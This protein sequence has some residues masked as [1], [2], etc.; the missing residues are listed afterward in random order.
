MAEIECP[1]CK[2]FFTQS[3]KK[4][5]CCS[6]TCTK[7]MKKRIAEK[8]WVSFSPIKDQER[9]LRNRKNQLRFSYVKD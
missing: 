4:P 3:L 6:S 8:K 9:T 2:N 5:K 7:E 1:I